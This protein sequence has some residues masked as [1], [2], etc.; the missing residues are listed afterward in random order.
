MRETRRWVALSLI[1]AA[2]MAVV[3]AIGA[4]TDLPYAYDA[5]AWAAQGA[6]Q[7]LV[8]LFVVL[9]VLVL[10]AVG[11]RRG[12]RRAHMIW[13]GALLYMVYSY[14]LY[15]LFVSFGPFFPIYVAVL[16]LSGYALAGAI[17]TM[18]R[19][20]THEG[21]RRLST[22]AAT[23][24]LIVGVGFSA[25]WLSE[26]LPAIASGTTP[27]MIE[28]F[29]FAVNPVHVLDLAFALPGTIAVA[30]LLYRRREAGFRFA[31][32]VAVFASLMGLA[33]IAMTVVMNARGL[34]ASVPV[35][36]GLGVV[37]LLGAVTATLLLRTVPA[38][39]GEST[40]G[41]A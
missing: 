38:R 10:S 6:G 35:A 17:A 7:D 4:F 2:L 24:L 18:G 26:I 21:R 37:V 31:P 5:P 25:L 40:L 20:V 23:Y 16:G 32:S 29:G 22:W 3:S 8:N 1:A 28:E 11:A 41:V 9:P 27:S 33:I 12:S 34:P 14:L 36:I 39:A 30:I 13:V 19:D 15:S